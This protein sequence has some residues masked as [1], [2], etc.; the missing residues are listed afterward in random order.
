MTPAAAVLVSVVSLDTQHRL[1]LLS[2]RLVLPVV[3][4]CLQRATCVMPMFLFRP[5]IEWGSAKSWGG[6]G[7]GK[8]RRV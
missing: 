4:V 8:G 2:N 7:D 6:G 5:K 1:Q 3:A